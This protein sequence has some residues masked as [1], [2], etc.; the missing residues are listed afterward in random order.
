M[1]NPPHMLRLLFWLCGLAVL[2]LSL[3]P[4]AERLPSTGWDKS[5][6][7]LAFATLMV[8]G[9]T[10]Y[11]HRRVA[12]PA[13]LLLFGAAIEVLQSF[14]PHRYAEWG[15]LLADAIGIVGGRVLLLLIAF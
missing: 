1:T 14:T 3:A 12:L 2:V 10:A 6:H 11:P 4:H 9:L 8:L 13:G 5:N 15:D 7:F